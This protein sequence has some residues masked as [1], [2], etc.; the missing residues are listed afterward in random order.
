MPIGERQRQPGRLFALSDKN[1]LV[2]I[3]RLVIGSRHCFASSRAS[4]YLV[5][6]YIASCPPIETGDGPY[7]SIHLP[8]RS[9]FSGFFCKLRRR[10]RERSA[11]VCAKPASTLALLQHSHRDRESRP[12]SS[13]EFQ[14]A[15]AQDRF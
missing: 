13:L 15:G 8:H 7:V 6:F 9:R 3:G 5:D 12:P 14:N 11:T 10:N 2:G 1:L 4:G